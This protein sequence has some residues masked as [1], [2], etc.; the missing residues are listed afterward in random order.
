MNAVDGKGN[1]RLKGF[2]QEYVS[3]TILIDINVDWTM[4]IGNHINILFQSSAVR[5]L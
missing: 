3:Y 5:V 1:S 2:D 4:D